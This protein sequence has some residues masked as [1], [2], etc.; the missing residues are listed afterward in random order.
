MRRQNDIKGA[1]SACFMPI[2]WILTDILLVRAAALIGLR[3]SMHY[4][5]IYIIFIMLT[6]RAPL[7]LGA[8]GASERDRICGHR[9]ANYPRADWRAALHPSR[10]KRAVEGQGGRESSLIRRKKQK[11][12]A[13]FTFYAKHTIL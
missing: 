1:E 6:C 13:S 9:H 8:A 12:I 3:V 2:L 7:C 11:C 10:S 5:Y 4:E